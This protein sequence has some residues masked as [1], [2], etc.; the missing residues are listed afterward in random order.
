MTTLP[1]LESIHGAL[2]AN[3]VCARGILAERGF[4]WTPIGVL[5]FRND[6]ELFV[7][8]STAVMG[9]WYGHVLR[10]PDLGG[11]EQWAALLVSGC[12]WMDAPDEETLFQRVAHWLAGRHQYA[13]LVAQ[14]P[15]DVFALR[16]DFD[17]AVLAL[18]E[19]I[20][21]F[22][23]I[24]RMEH[25]VDGPNMSLLTIRPTSPD[26]VDYRCM[27][28]YGCCCANDGIVLKENGYEWFPVNAEPL[29]PRPYWDHD[30]W[31]ALIERAAAELDR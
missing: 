9:V 6:Q 22:D 13:P 24:E 25:V 17:A 19:M 5:S 31:N 4:A 18:S 28:V 12:D 16:P 10:V 15:E 30:R 7:R 20:R 3:P 1:N 21:K 27:D 29:P 14:G 26:Q 23:P 8:V 2:A 11:A